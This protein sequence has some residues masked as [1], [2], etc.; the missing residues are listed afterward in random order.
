VRPHQH[1]HRHRHRHRR[2][3]QRQR[4]HQLQRQR[5]RQHQLGAPPHCC[6]TDVILGMTLVSPRAQANNYKITD[7]SEVI[8][9]EGTQAPLAGRAAFLTACTFICLASLALVLTIFEQQAFG[10][11]LGNIWY[12][13]TLAAPLAG[14]YYLENAERT[15]QVSVKIVTED[16]EMTAE[17]VVQGDDEEVERFQKTLD[18]REKGMIYVKGILES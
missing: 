7:A 6:P 10:G 13:A 5:Q 17:I 11:G 18:L 9:F 1:Q 3:R 8:V 16:D 15:D 2:Q 14:K 4:Q 12:A